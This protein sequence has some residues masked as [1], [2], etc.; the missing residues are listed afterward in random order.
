MS[1]AQV[2]AQHQELQQKIA[3][4]DA[5]AAQLAELATAQG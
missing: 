2:S 4:V 1:S 3:A 5:K